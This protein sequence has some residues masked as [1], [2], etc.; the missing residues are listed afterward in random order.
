MGQIIKTLISSWLAQRAYP[1]PWHYRPVVLVL[2]VTLV[3]G[4]VATWLQIEYGSL[5][6]K[7]ALVLSTLSVLGVGW[8]VVLN[9]SERQRVLALY[10]VNRLLR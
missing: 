6:A 5:Q 10:P 3:G 8:L 2:S 4:L 9:K 7:T 1:L